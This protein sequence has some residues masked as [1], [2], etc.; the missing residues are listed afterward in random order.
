MI[1]GEWGGGDEMMERQR[2][3]DM[4]HRLKCLCDDTNVCLKYLYDCSP[5]LSE[6]FFV[7]WLFK[8]SSAVTVYLRIMYK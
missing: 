7:R 3:R 6:D 8:V 1:E 4:C 2:E 5:L